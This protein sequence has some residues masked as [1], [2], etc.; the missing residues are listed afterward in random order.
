MRFSLIFV[1]VLAGCGGTQRAADET[2]ASEESAEAS[3]E[4]PGETTEPVE[5]PRYTAC[6]AQP[7]APC[8]ECGLTVELRRN[9]PFTAGEYG[10]E[11]L[12]EGNHIRCA[13]EL[14]C[15]SDEPVACDVPPGAPNVSVIIEGCGGP[16]AQQRIAALR[17]A[18]NA[19]PAELRIEA[20]KNGMG[21]G[22]EAIEPQYTDANACGGTCSQARA[23]MT[24]RR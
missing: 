11:I 10:F 8:D 16:I 13:V 9:R 21:A 23:T 4:A 5:E 22:N 12:T 20:F 17:F 19:C 2:S 18:S 6:P 14:P 7:S 1:S 24:Y 3:G 15:N